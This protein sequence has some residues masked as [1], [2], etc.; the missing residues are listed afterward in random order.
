MESISP[1]CLSAWEKDIAAHTLVKSRSP[2]RTQ[3]RGP[4]NKQ[5]AN[6]RGGGSADA[7]TSWFAAGVYGPPPAEPLR[8]RSR[9]RAASCRNNGRVVIACKAYPSSRRLA[10]RSPSSTVRLVKPA[11]DVIGCTHSCVFHWP[12][13]LH[14][15]AQCALVQRV[16]GQAQV[17]GPDART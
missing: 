5:D 8:Y 6:P 1:L 4:L 7:Q 2:R 12:S 3:R 15:S 14:V 16:A 17:C 13:K 10:A 11:H 9:G